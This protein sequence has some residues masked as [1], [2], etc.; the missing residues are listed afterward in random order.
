MVACRCDVVRCSESLV[1][2]VTSRF[3]DRYNR[4]LILGFYLAVVYQLVAE[5][6]VSAR[7][8]KTCIAF[9]QFP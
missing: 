1:S 5:T 7:K 6:D 3:L 2:K 4:D 8:D 9:D